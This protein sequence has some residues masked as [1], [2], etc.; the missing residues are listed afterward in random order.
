MKKT[1]L[2]IICLLIMPVYAICSIDSTDKKSCS[3]SGVNEN[4]LPLYQQSKIIK[5]DMQYKNFS[6]NN[7]FQQI[8]NLDN[9]INNNVN[10]PFGI[11]LENENKL[12][13]KF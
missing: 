2:L 10:C 5:N 13:N 9:N 7:S 12:N 1:F 4:E 3:L 6:N 8:Q 11:C